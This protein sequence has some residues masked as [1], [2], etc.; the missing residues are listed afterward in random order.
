MAKRKAA[1]TAADRRSEAEHLI[2]RLAESKCRKCL[3]P[4]LSG[5]V[6]GEPKRIDRTRINCAGEIAAI[7]AGCRT[8]EQLMPGGRIIERRGYHIRAGLPRLGYILAEHRC[9]HRWPPQHFDL[10]EIFPMHRGDEAPF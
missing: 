8:F 1:K 10:R 6:W 3:R 2:T 7:Y 5:T 9:E 4:T